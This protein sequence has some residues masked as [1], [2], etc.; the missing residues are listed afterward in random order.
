MTP[1]PLPIQQ[2]TDKLMKCI[3]E[4]KTTREDHY[5]ADM[6]ELS[7]QVR[8][9]G[10]FPYFYAKQEILIVSHQPLDFNNP[11]RTQESEHFDA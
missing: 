1:T 7:K 10:Y 4:Y 8:D 2:L 11:Y 6:R 3:L 5:L 9:A